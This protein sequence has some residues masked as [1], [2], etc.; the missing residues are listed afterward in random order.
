MD[1]SLNAQVSVRY[2]GEFVV[3]NSMFSSIYIKLTKHVQ[4]QQSLLFL[5]N[6]VSKI[7]AHHYQHGSVGL[8]GSKKIK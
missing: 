7:N 4:T 2:I 6:V 1:L 5:S 3:F 8:F